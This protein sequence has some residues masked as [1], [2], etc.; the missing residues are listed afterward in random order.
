M[1]NNLL[2]FF[3]ISLQLWLFLRIYINYHRKKL[4][5]KKIASKCSF[6]FYKVNKG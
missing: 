3:K 4:N 2:S 6:D 5:L 1:L